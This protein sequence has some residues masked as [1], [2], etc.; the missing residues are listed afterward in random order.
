MKKGSLNFLGR[1]NQSLFDT[2][3]KMKDMDN[4]ELVLGSSTILESG[5]ASVRARPTVKH[6]STSDSFHA[7]AVPT[8]TVPHYVPAINGAKINGSVSDDQSS[9]G[10]AM[11][12]SDHIEG[13]IFVP[14]PPSM[15]PPPPPAEV[16]VL[17]PPEFM[18]DLSTLQPPPMPAPKPPIAL[19]EED[20]HFLPPPPMSPPKPP[21]TNS[22][23]SGPISSPVATIIPEHP[24]YAP[25]QPPAEPKPKT[26]KSPPPK[27]IRISSVQNM[28]SPPASP[29]PPPP[30]HT[31]TL[32]TFNPQ[33]PAK[34]YSVPKSTFMNFSEQSSPKIKPKLL[35]E[36]SGAGP[37]VQ[38]TTNV[39]PKSTFVQEDLKPR[40]KSLEVQ[41][42]KLPPKSIAVQEETKPRAKSTDVQIDIKPQ[43]KSIIV[44]ED[45]KP[46]VPKP[47]QEFREIETAPKLSI[48]PPPSTPPQPA[49]E[50]KPLTAASLTEIN[51]SPHSS[52]LLKTS[53]KSDKLET[54]NASPTL[55]GKYSPLIDRKLR[56]ISAPSA[57]KDK[58]PLALLMAA[59]ERE[60]QKSHAHENSAPSRN[61]LQS[62]NSGSSLSLNSME[63]RPESPKTEPIYAL[64]V[65]NQK[66][67]ILSCHLPVCFQ[68]KHNSQHRQFD[69]FD[70]IEP[71][72][73]MKAPDPPK[74]P[75]P[76]LPTP[77]KLSTQMPVATP[78]LPTP[79]KLPAQMPVATPVLP[80]PPKL[81]AQMSVATTVTPTSPKSPAQMPMATPV[82]PTPPKPAPPPLPLL[83][84]PTLDTTLKSKPPPVLA[85]PKS[86]QSPPLAPVP[87][88]TPTTPSQATL[89]NILKK[90]MMEMDQKMASD[91]GEQES[92]SDDWGSP[93]DNEVP[94]VMIPKVNV[95]KSTV[96]TKS[97]TL[98]MKELQS[99]VVQKH[100]EPNRVPIPTSNGPSRHKYGMTFTVR[101]GT[102]EP[103]TLVSKGEP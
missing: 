84:P 33:S 49:P 36:D 39:R 41:D 88:P 94:K 102:K 24:K 62:T 4:V 3:V 54:P 86:T 70:D 8:P 22:N 15:A 101:P 103:I 28:D 23:G 30:A 10:S 83:P 11:S 5:T 57:P 50:R 26:F 77:P 93:E 48:P 52:P 47:V 18:G 68:P 9:N 81:P 78:V 67:L 82:L 25:P 87:L 16:F 14:A 45:I 35:L 65:K 72:P 56:N 29:A 55:S 97:A 69:D 51:K 34:I 61:S 58:S 89:L 75:A 95:P 96:V 60:K 66:K 13:E 40:P 20:Y 21:S 37:V 73:S 80:T 2:N 74:M 71:P 99:K 76:V 7:F 6:Y 42:V 19:H 27:P 53:T 17:P 38:N 44:E 98:D 1:K 43:P 85:K 64:P 31:P 91:V 63:G 12:V 92:N 32:S 79:P 90:K 46:A 100:P 59:K